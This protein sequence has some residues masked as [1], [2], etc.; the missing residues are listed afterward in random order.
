VRRRRDTNG[1][2]PNEYQALA[3]QVAQLQYELSVVRELLTR[4]VQDKQTITFDATNPVPDG[5]LRWESVETESGSKETTIWFIPAGET[6]KTGG[7][8]DRGEG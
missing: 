7:E 2:G 8:D 5:Q 1:A 4:I 6:A 3:E